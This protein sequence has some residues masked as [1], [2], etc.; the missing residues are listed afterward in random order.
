MP[1]PILLAVEVV[2]P[3]VSAVEAT[4]TGVSLR[5]QRCERT[6]LE[7]HLP[8]WIS[9][10]R[11]HYGVEVVVVSR[12][13]RPWTRALTGLVRQAGGWLDLLP[14][15]QIAEALEMAST[16]RGVLERGRA[17]LLA[18][19]WSSRGA[20]TLDPRRLVRTWWMERLRWRLHCLELLE[21][22]T[23]SVAIGEVRP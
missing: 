7:Q 17:S 12:A 16:E 6:R 14:G 9:D 3:L 5:E 19:L 15:E 18:S 22:E 11:S 13:G 10:M 20:N 2:G 8:A 4:P 21:L 23:P 1:D